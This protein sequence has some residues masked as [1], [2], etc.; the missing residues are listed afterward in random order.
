MNTCSL[1]LRP[2]ITEKTTRGIEVLNAYVFE[3]RADANK[4]TVRKAIEETFGVK[5]VKVNM[6][7]RKGKFKRLGRSFG[8]GKDRKE[9][10]VTLRQ[11]DKLD[12]Y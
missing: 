8:Y 3:V 11:G 6:R 2:V 1:L 10:V 7:N 5:V 12:I 9:A 4:L